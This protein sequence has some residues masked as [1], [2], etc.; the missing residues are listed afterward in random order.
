MTSSL[1]KPS[2]RF[3]PWYLVAFFV[4]LVLSLSWFV[5]IAVHDYPG[6]VTKDAYK[7]GLKYNQTIEKSEAQDKLGWNSDAN[8]I[9]HGR[10]IAVSFTL[11]DN[12]AKSIKNAVTNVWFIRPT[13]AGKDAEI[14]LTPDGK[15]NYNGKTTLAWQGEWEVHI[16]ATSNGHNYQQVKIINLE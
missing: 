11:T 16:S 13:H 10:E 6:E 8:F 7:K 2:D 3:I 4:F 5:W 14:S 15:G 12:H 1:A 9:M